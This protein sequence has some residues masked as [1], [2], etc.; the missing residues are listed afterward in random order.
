MY[1]VKMQSAKWRQ[2]EKH[3]YSGSVSESL[4]IYPSNKSK[5]L[6]WFWEAKKN[7]LDCPFSVNWQLNKGQKPRFPDVESNLNDKTE[8]HDLM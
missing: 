3:M 4:S 7:I 1:Q 2:K 8:V 6:A 5:Y